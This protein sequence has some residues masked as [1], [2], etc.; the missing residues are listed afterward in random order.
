MSGGCRL[1]FLLGL[2]FSVLLVDLDSMRDPCF[3]LVGEGN[4]EVDMIYS[5]TGALSP[6]L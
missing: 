4:N 5:T 3:E 6:I 2:A 1:A